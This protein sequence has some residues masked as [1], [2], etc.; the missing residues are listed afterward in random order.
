MNEVIA[1]SRGGVHVAVRHDSAVGH[2]TGA[3]R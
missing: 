1:R 3:A 2:V